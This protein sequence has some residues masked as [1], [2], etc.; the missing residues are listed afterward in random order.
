MSKTT[1]TYE[2]YRIYMEYIENEEN[3]VFLIIFRIKILKN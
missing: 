2:F 1:I 3:I